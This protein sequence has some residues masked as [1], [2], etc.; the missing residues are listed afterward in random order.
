LNFL[1]LNQ[2]AGDDF[3]SQHGAKWIREDKFYEV[4]HSQIETVLAKYGYSSQEKYDEL[5]K[6]NIDAFLKNNV[7]AVEGDQY[8]DVYY[9]INSKVKAIMLAQ[10]LEKNEV[11]IRI[12]RLGE[13]ALTDALEKVAAELGWIKSATS[14][15]EG[16][17]EVG[18]SN[19]TG[20]IDIPAADRIVSLS[21]NQQKEIIDATKELEEVLR[22]E[23]SIGDDVELR[24][25]F[26][27]QIAAGRELVRATS[28][29]AYLVYETFV[30][31]LGLLIQK[32]KDKALGIAAS[33]V[34][35][36]LVEYII[37]KWS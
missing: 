27:A 8:T 3:D 15:D 9:R 32:Y 14:L 16:E 36:V 23:N 17:V 28:V 11:R 12:S 35:D 2:I 26:L 19:G 37:G 24:E 31:M 34:L 21:H 29:R 22:Q 25:R 6:A 10:M 7:I 4:M 13:S 1:F 5:I 33:K 20:S 18:L 30:Q